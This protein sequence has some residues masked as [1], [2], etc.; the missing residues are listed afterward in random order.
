MHTKTHARIYANIE[1]T[2]NQSIYT[3]TLCQRYLNSHTHKHTDRHS[4]T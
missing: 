3:L 1:L 4:H 2:H